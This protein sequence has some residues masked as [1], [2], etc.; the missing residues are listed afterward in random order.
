ME[1][2]DPQIIL[3]TVVAIATVFYTGVNVMMWYESRKTRKQETTPNIIAFN[4]STITLIFPPN[5][6]TLKVHLTPCQNSHKTK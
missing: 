1:W 4:I 2:N 5:I 6:Y 3:S